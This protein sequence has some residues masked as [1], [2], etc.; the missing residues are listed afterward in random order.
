M[1]ALL[2]AVRVG[3]KDNLWVESSAGLWD[4]QWAATKAAMKAVRKALLRVDRLVVSMADKKGQCS[5]DLMGSP[6]AEKWAS[7]WA[8]SLA[9]CSAGT[10]AR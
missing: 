3:P 7:R 6:T 1:A 4:L 8:D 2:A 10:M 5:A 9:D